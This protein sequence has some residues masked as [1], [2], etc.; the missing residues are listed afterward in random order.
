MTAD[1]VSYAGGLWNIDNGSAY[2]YLNASGGS[3]TGDSWWWTMSSSYFTWSSSSSNS[4]RAFFVHGSG[5]PGNFGD[6]GIGNS[7]GVVRP[8]VSIKSCATVSNGDGSANNPYE[9][10]ISNTCSGYTATANVTNGYVSTSENTKS[11]QSG[12]TTEFLI[13]PNDGYKLTGATVS[14]TSG[15]SLNTTTGVLTMSNM[16]SNRTCT[17][18]LNGV[19]LADTI[20]AAYPSK[21][22]RS[23]F[24]R[25]YTTTALHEATD[26]DASGSFSGT[27]YY[28]TGNPNNWVSFSGSLWRIIRING[29]GSVR[30]LYAGSGGEDGYIGNAQGYNTS[31]DHPSYVGWKYTY[32]VNSTSVDTDRG[33]GT[34]SNAYSEVEKWY[35][36]NIASSYS[37]YIDGNAIYCNDR[38][39]GSGSYSTSSTFYYAAYTRL[40]TNKTPTYECSNAA[41]RFYNFG[42]MTADEVSYAGGLYNTKNGSAYYSLNASGGSSTGSNLWWTMSPSSFISSGSA[43]VFFVECSISPGR[44]DYT[45]VDASV[46]VRPVVSLKSS[47]LVTGGSGTGSD[48]YTLTME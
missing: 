1:E 9:L 15:C 13:Q 46:V 2:Y 12:G 4:A 5:T 27:S 32:N 39:I 10:S 3:S 24:S 42:L 16:T 25:V 48:P 19:T 17:V 28:F 38:N 22:E 40:A 41:D 35:N 44:F 37:N 43:D 34:K 33:N 23:S 47:V 20:K 31:K 7:Y 18:K 45:S 8:V 21:G 11:V 6:M 30:L 29:N 26:Y 36:S 14:P